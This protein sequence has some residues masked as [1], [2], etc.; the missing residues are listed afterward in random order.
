MTI[1]NIKGNLPL[2]LYYFATN[3]IHFLDRQF[4]KNGEQFKA[5][6]L[7]KTIICTRNPTWL[8]HIFVKNQK[9]YTKDFTMRQLEFILGKGLLTNTG[10]AWLKQRRL[11]QTAFYKGR[12]DSL[13][14]IME[15]VIE[16][17]ID[18][19]KNI[20]SG[21]LFFID[22]EMLDMTASVMLATIFGEKM[23]TEWKG[24]QEKMA[25]I[26]AYIVKRIQF[27]FY[28]PLAYM[29]GDH[30]KAQKKK[31]S[32]DISIYKTI[33]KR[34]NHPI[35]HF[36][37]VSML[38]NARDA[39]T[40]KRMPDQQLR[41]ELVTFYFA[42]HETTAFALSWTFYE[43]MQH[44]EVVK[45][46]K[47]EVTGVMVNGRIGS[48]GIKKLP[49]TTAV[50]HESLRL[51]PPAYIISRE[52]MENDVIENVKIKKGDTIIVSLINMHK[53]PELWEN[54]LD[55]NPE[56]FMSEDENLHKNLHPFGAGPRICIGKHF[57]MM[58]IILA[59]AKIV[60]ALDFI[61]APNQKIEAEAL[62]TLKPKNGIMVIKK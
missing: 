2:E 25:D 13:A 45:K 60:P 57:A 36:N 17:Y 19:M 23:N 47:K 8:E 1:P 20:P 42:G 15:E 40:G 18:K 16:A 61:L 21:S 31:N 38:V 51:H 12:L 48:D 30:Q 62:I 46:I 44:P 32:I 49:Y 26:Q 34:K 29:N 39:E 7:N 53:H 35:D 14:T 55:F 24:V 5:T 27:P 3:P 11:I 50:I 59:V 52:C 6:I 56:R 41:D 9:N 22:E 54:P 58:E 33:E 10:E 4:E 43:L 37:L 28:I